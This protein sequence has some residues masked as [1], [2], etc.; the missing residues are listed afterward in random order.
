MGEASWPEDIVRSKGSVDGDDMVW[1]VRLTSLG[2]I[3]HDGPRA[4]VCAD[5]GKVPEDGLLVHVKPE[6]YAVAYQ[7]E[8]F[9]LERHLGVACGCA[10][11][12]GLVP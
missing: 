12:R 10:A 8:T 6:T 9:Y 1:L 11:K 4:A 7:C 2:K 3:I 5:C